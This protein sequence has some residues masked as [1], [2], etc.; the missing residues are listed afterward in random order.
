MI[1]WLNRK[2]EIIHH[3]ILIMYN[4]QP[5]MTNLVTEDEN[6]NRNTEEYTPRSPTKRR[7]FVNA[8]NYRTPVRKRIVRVPYVDKRKHMRHNQFKDVPSLKKK[9]SV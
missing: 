4:S 1:Y 6:L 9:D 3:V 5:N 7:S 2:F 8:D